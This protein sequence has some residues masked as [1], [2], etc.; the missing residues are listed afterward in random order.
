[1]CNLEWT[2]I[3]WKD[4]L[5]NVRLKQVEESRTIPIPAPLAPALRKRLRGKSP[6][7]PVFTDG[8][9]EAF[10]GRLHIRGKEELL[11]IK[12]GEVDLANLRIVARRSYAWKPKGTNGAVPMCKEV[13]NLLERLAETKASNFVFPH[14]DGGPCRMD[15]LAL[16]KKAQKMAGI[17]GR[18]RIHD[19]RHTLGRRL[20]KDLGVPLET[21]M[22]ILR[23]AD[24][25]E[26]LIYAP[27]SLE[28]GRAAMGKLDGTATLPAIPT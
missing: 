17:S 9:L 1:M 2:D 26:T 16:L 19:L 24:I 7:E 23:H 10:A 13:R 4:G 8:D 21:I 28:E 11:A 15:L 3:D 5:I 6:G 25:R 27:Y 12:V 14:R 20:R 22:G 18:L